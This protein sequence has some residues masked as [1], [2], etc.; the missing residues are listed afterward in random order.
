LL[1]LDPIPGAP[2]ARASNYPQTWSVSAGSFCRIGIE[3]ASV[4]GLFHFSTSSH[5]AVWHE[6]DLTQF[7]MMSGM[8]GKA[9]L[10]VARPDFSVLTLS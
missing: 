2:A 9:D 5:V 3:A 10:T 1:A 8:E 6:T 4:G 7:M